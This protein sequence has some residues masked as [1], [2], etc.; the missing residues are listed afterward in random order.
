MVLES[1]VSVPNVRIT[2]I[3]DL[4]LILCSERFNNLD[5]VGSFEAV[6]SLKSEQ[7][8]SAKPS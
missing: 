3:T 6:P 2:E 7:S 5:F 4:S 1:A 8:E